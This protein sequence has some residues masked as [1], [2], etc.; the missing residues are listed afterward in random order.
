M[1]WFDAYEIRARMVPT[2]IVGLPLLVTLPVAVLQTPKASNLPFQIL[3]GVL[4][5][6]AILYTFSFL[7]RYLGKRIEPSL[8]TTWGG[9]PSTRFLRWRDSTF[10][11][12]LKRKLHTAVERCCDVQLR[13]EQEEVEDRA[14]AD[15]KIGQAFL[16]IK[17]MVR[18][19]Q[20]DGVWSKHNAE[21][22]FNRNLLGSRHLW[23]LLSVSCTL[24]CSPLLY[25][26]IGDS[27]VAICLALNLGFVL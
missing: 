8:W 5:S 6:L 19:Q 27:L 2:L 26:G 23:L 11:S 24:A 4:L 22:G 9:A 16:Q 13:S 1:G 21:Y 25:F 14:D 15:S 12:D 17:S 7:V 3:G 18:N 10:N 20:P